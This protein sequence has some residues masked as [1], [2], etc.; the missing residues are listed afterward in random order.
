MLTVSIIRAMGMAMA[1]GN[2]HLRNAGKYLPN[3][4]EQYPRTLFTLAAC[5]EI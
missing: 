2:K 1:M 5:R 4:E 3:Y